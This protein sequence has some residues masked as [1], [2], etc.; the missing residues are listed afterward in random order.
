[1]AQPHPIGFEG[2]DAN[3]YRYCGNDAA[4]ASDPSGLSILGSLKDG[5]VHIKGKIVEYAT[6][7]IPA[8]I[9]KSQWGKIDSFF[10]PPHAA[11]ERFQAGDPDYTTTPIE[12]WVEYNKMIMEGALTLSPM[13]GG[14]AGGAAAE[15]LL[16]ARGGTGAAAEASAIARGEA[17]A[18]RDALGKTLGRKH[19]TYTAGVKDGEIAVGCSKN[20]FG[21]AED[22]VARQLGSDCRFT[23]AYGWRRNAETRQLEWREIDICEKCQ[24]KYRPEQFPPDVRAV[25]GG[26]WER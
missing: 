5:L 15:E 22:D 6:K 10:T 16:T 18:A 1:M 8:Y 25:R 3:L 19:A 12:M 14:R 17:R 24:M 7:P 21:C 20:P 2:G 4:N 11:Y 23:E 9:P 13:F 26:A